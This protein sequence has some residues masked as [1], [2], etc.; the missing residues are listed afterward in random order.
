M[1]SD[2]EPRGSALSPDQPPIAPDAMHPPNGS[3]APPAPG[4]DIPAPASSPPAPP[5]SVSP[6]AVSKLSGRPPRITKLGGAA[7]PST[8]SAKIC[9]DEAGQVTAS[10][11]L[12]EL[13][14]RAATEIADALR[15]WRYAP[16]KVHGVARAA[17]FVDSVR[18]P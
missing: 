17:C 10:T 9:I 18:V 3:A 1:P 13:P 15:T 4:Q 5:A 12:T 8:I 11:V 16:Y 14:A 6:T 7:L 2:H